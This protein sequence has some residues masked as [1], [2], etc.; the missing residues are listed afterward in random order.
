MV[1]VQKHGIVFDLFYNGPYHG[2]MLGFSDRHP[3]HCSLDAANDLVSAVRV[4]QRGFSHFGVDH[5]VV[6]RLEVYSSEI[7]LPSE[8]VAVIGEPPSQ[9][10]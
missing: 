1:E 9:G 4:G 6:V 8:T 7:T 10:A 3:L 5:L 2:H